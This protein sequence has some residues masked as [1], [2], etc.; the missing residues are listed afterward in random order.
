MPESR[1]SEPRCILRGQPVRVNCETAMCYGVC[2]SAITTYVFDNRDNAS[3][4]A[5][6]A[7]GIVYVLE[8]EKNLRVTRLGRAS[9]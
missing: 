4:G 6:C 2:V 8:P 1:R 7:D 5:I 9:R 3:Y